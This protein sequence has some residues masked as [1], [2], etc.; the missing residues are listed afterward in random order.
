MLL[1]SYTRGQILRDSWMA[2]LPASCH[3][4]ANSWPSGVWGGSWSPPPPLPSAPVLGEGER[5]CPY[6]HGGSLVSWVSRCVDTEGSCYWERNF[7]G[8]LQALLLPWG[9]KD[10]ET[11][12]NHVEARPASGPLSVILSFPSVFR[13]FMMKLFNVGPGF[14]QKSSKWGSLWFLM[15]KC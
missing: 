5:Q 2:V 9:F 1:L 10:S 8:F 11:S 12:S 6:P 15:W 3:S 13:E 14:Q 4:W 7:W